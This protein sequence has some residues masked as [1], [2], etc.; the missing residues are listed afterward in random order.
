[1]QRQGVP[2]SVV[3]FRMRRDGAAAALVAAF[4][5]G[6]GTTDGAAC[7][8][9]GIHSGQGAA[10]AAARQAVTSAFPAVRCDVTTPLLLWT[11]RSAAPHS[12]HCKRGFMS[13]AGGSHID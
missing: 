7:S 13:S 2:A 1:M 5:A 12:H 9:G 11:K 6:E 10:V 4:G 8:N 3:A